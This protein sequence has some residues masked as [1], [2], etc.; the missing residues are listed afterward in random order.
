MAAV[1]P[2]WI[3]SDVMAAWSD[4]HA[5]FSLAGDL[6]AAK[7]ALELDPSEGQWVYV[8]GLS[9]RAARARKRGVVFEKLRPDHTPEERAV[10]LD[11]FE[12][13]KNP[14]TMLRLARCFVKEDADRCIQ[15]V[16]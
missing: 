11:A 7:K 16:R 1:K 6:F 15:L 2:Y 3:A 10:F 13:R 14:Q 12:R 5:L 4:G 8:K 9:M